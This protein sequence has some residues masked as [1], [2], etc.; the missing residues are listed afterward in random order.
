MRVAQC[1]TQFATYF[2]Y[3]RP[4]QLVTSRQAEY[5]ATEICF[6]LRREPLPGTDNYESNRGS[7][8]DRGPLTAAPRVLSMRCE[9]C[10]QIA[11]HKAGRVLFRHFG[12]K[13]P[14]KLDIAEERTT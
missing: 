2:S 14:S 10:T 4:T 6:R 12:D 3:T 11:N 8:S 1:W 7:S 9:G 5:V 13:F